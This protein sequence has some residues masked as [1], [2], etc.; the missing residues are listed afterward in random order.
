L[1][2]WGMLANVRLLPMLWDLKNVST[3]QVLN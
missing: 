1:G 2:K 3:A